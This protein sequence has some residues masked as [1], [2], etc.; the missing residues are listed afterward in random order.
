M[1]PRA[2]DLHHLILS[3]QRRGGRTGWDERT[4]PGNWDGRIGERVRGK[5]RDE[6]GERREERGER[7]AEER[8]VSN[9]MKETRSGR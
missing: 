5:R 3:S 7:K 1:K 6:R 9:R 2:D 4:I 8:N